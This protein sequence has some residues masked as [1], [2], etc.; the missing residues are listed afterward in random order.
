MT[1]GGRIGR[2]MDRYVGPTALVLIFHRVADL[3]RDPQLL[4][5][6]PERFDAQMALLATR[7]PVVSLGDLAEGIRANALPDKA[8]AVTFDDGYADNLEHAAPILDRHG[9]PATVFVSSGYVRSGREFWWDELER[10]VLASDELPSAISLVSHGLSYEWSADQAPVPP[11]DPRW[12]VSLPDANARERL[13]RELHALMRPMTT[14]ARDAILAELRALVGADSTARSTHRPLTSAEVTRLDAFG[15]IE[16]AG[17]TVDH[18]VL[19]TLDDNEQRRQ[20]AEDRE[21]LG[22][23]CSREIGLFSY[24][25]GAL[26]DYTDRTVEIVRD[27]GYR[28]ACSN[29]TGV[30]KPRTDPFRIPRHLVRNWDAETL[31]ERID[32]WFGARP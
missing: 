25:Y 5:V 19:A 7:H 29:H 18:A 16:V 10:L 32:R 6:S 15:G 12:N 11:S 14:P 21:D 22:E 1:L 2:L 13:Y 27:V 17:H 26:A 30:V 4:A 3:E 23:M 24:P 9:V 31:A 20:I 28:A 8:I